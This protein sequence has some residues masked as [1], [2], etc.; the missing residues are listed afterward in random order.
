MSAQTYTNSAVTTL[1]G[2]P[3]TDGCGSAALVPG[4]KTS[5]IN[6][7]ISGQIG[8]PALVVFSLSLSHAWVSDLV[9]TLTTPAGT[10][11]GLMKRVA[12]AALTDS[13][14]GSGSDLIAANPLNFSAG[15]STQFVPLP[16]A[17]AVNLGGNFA[18]SGQIGTAFPNTVTLCD[19][20][21]LSGVAIYGDWN[22]TLADYGGGDTGTLNS[23]SINFPTGSLANTDH[24]AVF[25]SAVSVMENPFSDSLRLK[26]NTANLETLTFDVYSIDGKRIHSDRLASFAENSLTIDTSSWSSGTYVIVPVKNGIRHQSLQVVKN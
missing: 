5:T 23:W 8:N 19:L 21:A 4:F 13:G 17:S 1:E 2:P 18:P 11:C 16:V 26:A 20:Y 3:D 10:T 25:S 22:L 9:I 12:A 24:G 6:V 14:C 15:Y 7:P